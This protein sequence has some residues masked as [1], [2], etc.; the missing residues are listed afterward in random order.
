MSR[1]SQ[2]L[3]SLPSLSQRYLKL[4][5][6]FGA[7]LAIGLAPLLGSVKILGLQVILSLFPQDLQLVVIPFA[8]FVMALPPLGAEFAAS[9]GGV[10]R[11]VRL[12]VFAIS[13]LAVLAGS[14]SLLAFY[15]YSVKRV[16]SAGGTIAY[17]VGERFLPKC[18][19][20]AA[21]KK[22]ELCVG[23]LI[24]S[25]PAEVSACYDDE[26]IARRKLILSSLYIG[27]MLCFGCLIAA[28]IV[29]ENSHRRRPRIRK[30]SPT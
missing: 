8:A 11:R 15:T 23:K 12:A 27:T 9:V 1:R 10:A 26:V 16:P 2:K 29:G 21:H 13:F 20:E 28:L 5:L 3:P 30:D 4:C 25:D 6:A 17:V 24:S 19:C 14:V 22:L 18:P 7:T